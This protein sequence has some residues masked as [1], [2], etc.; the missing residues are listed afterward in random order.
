MFKFSD[1]KDG[2]RRDFNVDIVMSDGNVLRADVLRP[3]DD[4]KHP[5]ILTYGPYAKGLA[6]H[7][8]YK[9]ALT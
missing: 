5:V 9:E 8:V 4:K 1:V 6:F 2:M 7:D 3:D